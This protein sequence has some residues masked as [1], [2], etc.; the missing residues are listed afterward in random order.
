[1]TEQFLVNLMCQCELGEITAEF[2]SILGGLMHQM[3]KVTTEK[4]YIQ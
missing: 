1:M 4:G 3:Y 2:E